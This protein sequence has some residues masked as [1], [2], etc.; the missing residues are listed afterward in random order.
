MLE[1]FIKSSKGKLGKMVIDT[2]PENLLPGNISEKAQ[3]DTKEYGLWLQKVWRGYRKEAM[4]D[5]NSQPKADNFAMAGRSSN[6]KTLVL[7]LKE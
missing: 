4:E 3:S 2:P 6:T 7:L 5:K 1:G